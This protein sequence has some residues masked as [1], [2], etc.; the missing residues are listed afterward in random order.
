MNQLSKNL[1]SDIVKIAGKKIFIN[2]FLYFRRLDKSTKNWFREI[3]QLSDSVI[4]ENRIRFYPELDWKNLT[5]DEER[6]K[7]ATVEMLL[8][9]LEII[10]TFHP[11]L[12]LEQLGIVEKH[13]ITF[14]KI[15][16]EKLVKQQFRK[17]AKLLIAEK[18]R[19]ERA[20]FLLNWQNW[21]SLK[22]TRKM[23][24][25][26]FVIILLSALIGWFAG[27]SK[28]SCNPYFE[29]VNSNQL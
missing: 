29:S 7:N 13:L 10:N 6:V 4:F 5:K 12:S 19:L 24:V 9:T 23:L 2:P 14:K 18:K 21:L 27:L 25:P 8:K 16:F 15:S 26:V 22:Q 17:N 11:N 28:N 20:D 3:N 1:Q